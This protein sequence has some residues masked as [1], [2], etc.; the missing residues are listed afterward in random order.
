MANPTRRPAKRIYTR[1]P[2]DTPATPDSE[3]RDPALSA[4]SKCFEKSSDLDV[5]LHC[6]G[7]PRVPGIPRIADNIA[8]HIIVICID[9]EHWSENTDKTTEVGIATFARQDVLPLVARNEFGDHGENLIKQVKFYLFRTIEN[10]HLPCRNSRSR[11]VDGNRFGRARFATFEQCRQ[12]LHSLFFQSMRGLAGSQGYH[13]VVVLGQ[14][15]SHDRQNLKEKEIDFDIGP[16]VVRIIDTQVLVRDRQYWVADNSM[17]I[18]LSLLVRELW[19]EHSDPHT[20]ANDA[21]RTLIS[22]FQIALGGHE[23]KL[24]AKKTLLEVATGVEEYSVRNFRPIG[25][26]AQYCWR[27]GETG[28]MIVSCQARHLRCERCREKGRVVRRGEEHVSQH[29]VAYADEVAQER[30]VAN[31]ERKRLRTQN[32]RRVSEDPGRPARPTPSRRAS[33]G[34]DNQVPSN[35][36]PAVPPTPVGELPSFQGISDEEKFPSLPKRSAPS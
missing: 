5:L 9:C 28:H 12:I 2:T 4:L 32:L 29:C 18:G 16:N 10:V 17:Q 30:R 27:C 25:G 15:V 22:A 6:I 23:C 19:F 1:P 24:K 35:A 14:D 34:S 36:R 31:E 8:D 20:A 26:V 21:A 13:P 11:G 33:T 7:G 3:D